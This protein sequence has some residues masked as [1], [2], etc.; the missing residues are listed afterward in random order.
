[1]ADEPGPGLRSLQKSLG[2]NDSEVNLIAQRHPDKD[3]L[4]PAQFV[5]MMVAASSNPSLSRLLGGQANNAD[6]LR[7]ELL[8]LLINVKQIL[9]SDGPVALGKFLDNHPYIKNLGL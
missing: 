5:S 3:L 2:L 1:M 4:G 9:I 7:T 6:K 8:D